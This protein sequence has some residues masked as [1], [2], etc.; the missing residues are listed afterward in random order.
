MI[1]YKGG[2]SRDDILPFFIEV[3]TNMVMHAHPPPNFLLLFFAQ[4]ISTTQS[5]LVCEKA[6][7]CCVLSQCIFPDGGWFSTISFT[8]VAI[9]PI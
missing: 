1:N 4:T 2:V 8:D 6:N 3:F 7:L 9:W 5:L